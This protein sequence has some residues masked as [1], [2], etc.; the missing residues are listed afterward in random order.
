MSEEVYP[1]MKPRKDPLPSVFKGVVRNLSEIGHI[2]ELN[3]YMA[4]ER[5]R[6][7]LAEKPPTAYRFNEALREA[8]T[9]MANTE[10]AKKVNQIRRSDGEAPTESEIPPVC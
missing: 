2:Y 7:G 4:E 5:T 1:L 10:I 6:I 9:L 8:R 3:D